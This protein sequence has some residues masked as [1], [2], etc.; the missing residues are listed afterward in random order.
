MKIDIGNGKIL[1]TKRVSAN[2]QISGFSEYAGQE[3]L[4]VLPASDTSV[5]AA[6]RDLLEEVRAATHAYMQLAF[7]ESRAL[8]ERF[9]GPNEAAKAFLETTGPKSFKGLYE[10]VQT[11]AKDEAA[12][13]ETRLERARSRSAPAAVASTSRSR[14]TPPEEGD[15]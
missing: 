15:E 7:Q 12:K 4:V 8:K 10:K 13:A 5:D 11:W 2:G 1:G 6:P 3:V 9:R 14:T